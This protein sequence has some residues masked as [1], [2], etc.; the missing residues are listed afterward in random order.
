MDKLEKAQGV[1]ELM[2]QV[3]SRKDYELSRITQ[4]IK[5]HYLSGCRIN[6]KSNSECETF[7]DMKLI[8]YGI[9][10]ELVWSCEEDMY[11]GYSKTQGFDIGCYAFCSPEG[12]NEDTRTKE[13]FSAVLEITT[14]EGKLIEYWNMHSIIE[15]E[16]NNPTHTLK[17]QIKE[18]EK[19]VERIEWEIKKQLKQTKR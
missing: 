19:N 1:L 15:M 4:F 7:T 13:P 10:G 17:D 6:Y 2:T 3:K 12:F 18:C 8:S 14:I 11:S 5:D 16:I 9:L